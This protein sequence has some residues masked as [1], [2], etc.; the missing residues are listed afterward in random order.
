MHITN[1]QKTYMTRI[2]YGLNT[3]H[4]FILIFYI[5]KIYYIK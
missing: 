2:L 1:K 3:N 4:I 5:R